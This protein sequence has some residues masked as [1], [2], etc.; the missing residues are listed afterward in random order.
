[1]RRILSLGI[2]WMAAVVFGLSAVRAAPLAQ[3][4]QAIITSPSMNAVVRGQVVITGSAA[5]PNFWKYEIH[6][7]PEPNP[8]NQWS[9]IGIHENQVVDGTLEIWDTTT[10]PD[11]RYSLLLRVVDRTGNYQEFFVRQV[12]VSNAV[13]TET[14]TPTATRTPTNTPLPR[15]TPTVI[16]IEPKSDI[17]P[18]TP[19]PTL[20]R[21]TTA[22]VL[23]VPAIDLK[24]WRDAFLMGAG[25]MGAVFLLVGLIYLIRRLL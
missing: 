9:V 18:S 12:S 16:V 15:N 13:P 24:E 23:A 25:A 3:N 22:P 17:E 4:V 10:V 6:L 1:M 19:T 14:P 21:P 20:E 7:A 2:G 11:G 8:L 5:H